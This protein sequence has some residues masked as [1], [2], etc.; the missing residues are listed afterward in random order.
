[1]PVFRHA[2]LPQKYPEE[3]AV[4]RLSAGR[5]SVKVAALFTAGGCPFSI[6]KELV[7]HGSQHQKA[8]NKVRN[9]RKDR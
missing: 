3:K 7:F 1:M 2:P 4:L 8:T 9:L 6:F 5:K